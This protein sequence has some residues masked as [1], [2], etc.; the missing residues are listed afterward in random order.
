MGAISSII[1]SSGGL[2]PTSKTSTL[3]VGS[4]QSI[5]MSSIPTLVS[6][7]SGPLSANTLSTVLNLSGKGALG[8][9]FVSSVDTTSRT[10]R[11]KIT[12]DGTV[13]YDQTSAAVTTA[14]AV[15]A[16]Q[17]QLNWTTATNVV[18]VFEAPLFFESSLLIEYASSLPESGKTNFGY[19]YY[20]R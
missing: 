14:N 1:G 4:L 16:V 18:G 12:I 20:G 15:L 7:V 10:H 19:T 17:G 13:V 2:K 3:G 8:C 6:A 11:V 5:V 9:F